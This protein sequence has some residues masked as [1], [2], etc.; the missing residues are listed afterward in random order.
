[1][2]QIV[3]SYSFFRIN[4]CPQTNNKNLINGFL[5]IAHLNVTLGAAMFFRLGVEFICEDDKGLTV[6]AFLF[7]K[8]Y[9]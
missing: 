8:V 1:M 7:S 6:I 3:K 2:S 9:H 4:Y 5:L